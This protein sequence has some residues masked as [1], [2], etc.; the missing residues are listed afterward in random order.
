MRDWA[1]SGTRSRGKPTRFG[2]TT[3]RFAR[4]RARD[5]RLDAALELLGLARDGDAE[6]GP[7][8]DHHHDD[9]EDAERVGHRVPDAGQAGERLAGRGI[10]HDLLERL[11]GSGEGG[12][13]RRGAAQDA[14]HRRRVDPAEQVQAQCRRHPEEH[15]RGGEQVQGQ[16]V[17]AQRGEEAGTHLEAD[18][19]HEEDQPE[20]AAELQDSLV[21]VHTEMAEGEAGEQDSGD[22]QA[23]PP[24]AQA[25][26]GEAAPG[27]QGQD[28]HGARGGRS[29]HESW[30]RASPSWLFERGRSRPLPGRAR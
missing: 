21:D 24:H 28:E 15:D 17:T 1:S 3:S 18:R 16:P 14:R 9:A 11:L 8:P 13:V 22:P 26:Q 19:V 6:R 29:V 30:R 23:D 2:L 12:R 10:A 7:D 5:L 20:L 25:A 4:A 27:D